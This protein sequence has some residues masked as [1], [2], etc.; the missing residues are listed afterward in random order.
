MLPLPSPAYPD[1]APHGLSWPPQPG[2]GP[3]IGPTCQNQALVPCAAPAQLH[4]AYLSPACPNQPLGCQNTPS[5]LCIPGLGPV[6][7]NTAQ[8]PHMA[9]SGPGRLHHPLLAP[10]IEIRS[11][12]QKLS[13]TAGCPHPG[14]A[15]C[16][17]IGPYTILNT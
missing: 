15:P 9:G 14:P 4:T 8:R 13:T 17:R 3:F 5:Q 7:L 1:R 6:P 16:A 11:V 12:P 2:I 10:H